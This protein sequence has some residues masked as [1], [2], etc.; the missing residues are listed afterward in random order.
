MSYGA[1]EEKFDEDARQMVDPIRP[2]PPVVTTVYHKPYRREEDHNGISPPDSPTYF[3][4]SN[5]QGIQKAQQVHVTRASTGQ[6]LGLYPPGTFRQ[7]FAR[8]EVTNNTEGSAEGTWRTWGV[9]QARPTQ[10]NKTWKE[11]YM[12]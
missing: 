2:P 1:G 12:G 6:P 4:A 7:S 5:G 8:T 9:D 11:R 3:Q 10:G